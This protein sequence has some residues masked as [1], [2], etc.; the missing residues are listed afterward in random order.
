MVAKPDFEVK[1]FMPAQQVLEPDGDLK[2]E[3]R[4]VFDVAGEVTRLRMQFMDSANTELHTTG[5]NVRIRAF[6]G[7]D[8]FELTYKKRYRFDGDT[9]ERVLARAASDGFD[10]GEREY[11]AQ[12]EWGNRRTLSLSRRRS[13]ELPDYGDLDMPTEDDSRSIAAEFIPGKLD[14]SGPKDW[15]RAILFAGHVYGPVRG[16]RWTGQWDGGKMVIEV[17]NV[18]RAPHANER[19]VAEIS[20]KHD[21]EAQAAAR[22]DRLQNFLRSHD[23][24]RPDDVLKTDLILRSYRG[25]G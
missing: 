9:L 24:L 16:R 3:V 8:G 25:G 10:A 15:A 4:A 20:F 22:R 14:R 2:E 12:V 7:E 21:D 23:W 13:V 1:F 11:D 6:E 5:W 18:D 17:W 19:R